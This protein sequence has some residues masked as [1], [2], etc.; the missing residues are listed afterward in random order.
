MFSFF[1][2][3]FLF[4]LFIF[5]SSSLVRNIFDYQKKISFYQEYLSHLWLEKDRKIKLQTQI[6]KKTDPYYLEKVIRNKLNLSKPG[7]LV[8]IVPVP[9][10]SPKLL[11]PTPLPNWQQWFN[12][13]FKK[14]SL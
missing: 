8:V 11:T 14:N 12:L 2:K 9:T 7:D 3:T 13:F 5:L 4:F 10:D 6:L 1:K